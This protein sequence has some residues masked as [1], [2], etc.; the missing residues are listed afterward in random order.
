M[1]DHRND[2]ADSRYQRL[3]DNGGGFVPLKDVV[4]RAFVVAWPIS[5][6]ATL[7]VPATF[8]QS[9]LAAS[10][11]PVVVPGALDGL[12]LVVPVTLWYRRRR[13]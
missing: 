2:S 3:Q 9:G 7:S 13:R 1:G 8:K 10:T 6:W 4:G 12:A 5:H 11:S